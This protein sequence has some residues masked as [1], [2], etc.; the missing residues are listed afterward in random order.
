MFFEMGKKRPENE[1]LIK[2]IRK[3]PVSNSKT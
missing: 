3:K 1:L 2:N